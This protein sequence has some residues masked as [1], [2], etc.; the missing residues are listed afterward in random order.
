MEIDNI[1][2]STIVLTT[3]LPRGWIRSC[4]SIITLFTLVLRSH[5]VSKF[6]KKMQVILLYWFAIQQQT[7]TFSW[8]K[9]SLLYLKFIAEFNELS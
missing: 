2:T 4:P 6:L 8:E 1:R 3:A 5:C 7:S 9:F